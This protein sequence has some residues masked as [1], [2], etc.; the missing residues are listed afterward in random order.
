MLTALDWIL[1]RQLRKRCDS[2]MC[3][4]SFCSHPSLII[5]FLR[6]LLALRSSEEVSQ[7][8]FRA[9]AIVCVVSAVHAVG[10]AVVI[11]LQSISA[12]C[13]VKRRFLNSM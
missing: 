5:L 12:S 1:F 7:E 2:C 13:L 6:D 9:V 11:L 8:C 10:R 3:S 4:H